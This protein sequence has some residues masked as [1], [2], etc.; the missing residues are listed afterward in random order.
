MTNGKMQNL[1]QTTEE[2][3]V[4][5]HGEVGEEIL[6]KNVKTLFLLRDVC[7]VSKFDKLRVIRLCYSSWIHIKFKCFLLTF[8]AYL[9]LVP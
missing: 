3:R 7:F 8:W 6:N 1:V 9:S 4:L 2:V 5:G